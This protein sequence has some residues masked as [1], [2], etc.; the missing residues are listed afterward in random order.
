MWEGTRAD[1][2]QREVRKI[3]L[4]AR[5]VGYCKNCTSKMR[6]GNKAGNWVAGGPEV[7]TR[8]VMVSI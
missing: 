4:Y 3:I 7:K 5:A 1:P 2:D 8:R 6:V